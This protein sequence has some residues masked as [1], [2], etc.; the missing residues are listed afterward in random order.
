MARTKLT[1]KQKKKIIADYIENENIRETARINNVD[2]MTVKRLID[3]NYDED[4]IKK[5]T[6]KKQENTLSTLE[7]MDKQHETKKRIIDK[8]LKSIEIKS[9]N[10]DMFTNVKDLATAYGIILDKELKLLEVKSKKIENA[11]LGKVEEL[12]E[13]IE[14][15][16]KN[17]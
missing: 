1:D 16:A 3:S 9:E 8:L 14:K 10:T 13:K 11:Q 15:G 5:A 4:L 12:L 6:Q 17:E 7:Y 2:K